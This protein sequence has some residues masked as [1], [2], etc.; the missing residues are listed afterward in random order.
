MLDTGQRQIKPA[1][2]GGKQL[3]EDK[4]EDINI[5]KARFNNISNT[6]DAL[7]TTLEGR[8]NKELEWE[9]IIK[10]I[11]P[12]KREKVLDAGGGT[13]RITLLLAKLGYQVTLIDLSPG[14]L[15]IAR[16]KLRKEGLEHK[17]EIKEADISSMPFSDETFGLVICLHGPF[18][19]ADS[20]KVAKE[21]TRVLK[22]GGGIVVDT[23]SRYWAATSVLES[24]PEFALKLLKS[25]RNHA[26]DA[27]GDWQRVFSPDEFQ[28]LFRQNGI[29][30]IKIYGSFYQL[31]QLLSRECIEKQGLNEPFFSQLVKVMSCLNMIP[32]V[33]GM[34]REL[35]LTGEKR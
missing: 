23:L 6:F 32:S 30:N 13:G 10:A 31:P 24:D 26:Y 19:Y 17:V 2:H 18:C 12:D 25:E 33:I 5:V 22:M 11:L 20:P 15:T 28:E 8:L 4:T 16:E 1:F 35:I 7:E 27:H 14:M 29:K 9:G 3:R 21:F 34:A